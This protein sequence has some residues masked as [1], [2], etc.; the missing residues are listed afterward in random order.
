VVDRKI[1][2]ALVE[3]IQRIAARSHH[4]FDASP[5]WPSRTRFRDRAYWPPMR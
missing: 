2:H 3:V 1:R 4:L 5:G